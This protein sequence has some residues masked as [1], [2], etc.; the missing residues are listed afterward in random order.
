MRN[1]LTANVIDF[2]ICRS[3]VGTFTGAAETNVFNPVTMML[4]AVTAFWD[5][6]ASIVVVMTTGHCASHAA[7]GAVTSGEAA[8]QEISI[9]SRARMR[10][11]GC[12]VAV[13]F[14]AVGG[15]CVAHPIA[16]MKAIAMRVTL[17]CF[18]W[19]FL[20]CRCNEICSRYRCEDDWGNRCRVCH[21]D[22]ELYF[23]PRH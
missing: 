13:G 1:S 5:E 8:A 10:A 3:F 11:D 22:P 15:D 9:A 17:S 19:S 21:H 23:R 20:C 4:V 6:I 12:P 14:V 7:V 18:M 2:T 16:R